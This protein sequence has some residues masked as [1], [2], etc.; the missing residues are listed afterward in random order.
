MSPGETGVKLVKD[1]SEEQ[2]NAPISLSSELTLE[3]SPIP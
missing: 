3:E 1:F 2:I